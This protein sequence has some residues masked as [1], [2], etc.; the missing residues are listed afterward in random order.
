V[1]S[2]YWG[3]RSEGL[4]G[5]RAHIATG[6][7]QGL[8]RGGRRGQPVGNLRDYA[9]ESRIRIAMP[10]LPNKVFSKVLYNHTILSPRCDSPRTPLDGWHVALGSI[11]LPTI[12]L[13][14][15]TSL[16]DLINLTKQSTRIS[17][18]TVIDLVAF[19]GMRAHEPCNSALRPA[20]AKIDGRLRRISCVQ[21]TGA[22][23]HAL[24]C[25]NVLVWSFHRVCLTS[26]HLGDCCCVAV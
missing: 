11:S 19:I 23:P 12:A 8:A 9:P 5:Q 14:S 21:V 3:C 25:L 15:D 7:I 13:S 1:P 17:V 20:L 26:P 6:L 4:T 10:M 2:T 16:S 24:P 18:S 22:F